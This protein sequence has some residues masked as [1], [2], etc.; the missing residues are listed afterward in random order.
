MRRRSLLA[1]VLL[2]LPV[3]AAADDI[4]L[5]GGGKVSGRILSRTETSVE[6]DVGAGK[7]TLPMSAVLRIEERRSALHDYH[8]RA[9]AL[10]ADD[11]KG[12][13][14]LAR[15]AT[16][17]GLGTQARQAY[18]RVLRVDPS[19]P[20]ANRA[21]G[22]VLLDGVWM[23]EEQSYLAR[24]F[25]R[26]EGEW[27][28]PQEREAILRER[29]GAAEA[30]RRQLDAE[31]R[32]RDAELRAMEAE[33]RA[34]EAE[35]AAAPPTGGIPL[36][37]GWGSWGP[38][39]VWPNPPIVVPPNPRPPGPRPPGPRPPGPRP[40]QSEAGAS[41]QSASPPATA[42]PPS[43]PTTAPPNRPT[44]KPLPKPG[45]KPGGKPG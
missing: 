10:R 8:D 32:A 5:K 43:A 19:H 24:G 26:F 28:L 41:P 14:E 39:P 31:V 11:A 12:W 27:M 37:W 1:G 25:V 3:M 29:Q 38:W 18:E 13:L 17:Q 36:W 7:V 42:S 2:L 9:S 15:W 45:G 4:Y 6:I 35:A 44:T 40:K 16:K 34:R 22:N 23:T 21:V 30:E 33:A 20:E